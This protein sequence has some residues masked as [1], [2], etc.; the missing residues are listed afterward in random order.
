MPPKRKA[1]IGQKGAKKSKKDTSL[2]SS[3]DSMNGNGDTDKSKKS[4]GKDSIEKNKQGF[5]GFTV[6]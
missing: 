2:N 6:V 5:S 4:Q 3:L 1:S